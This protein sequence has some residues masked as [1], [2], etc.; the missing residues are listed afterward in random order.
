[1]SAALSPTTPPVRPA[2]TERQPSKC[3]TSAE[4]GAKKIY[5]GHGGINRRHVRFHGESSSGPAAE[6]TKLCP[7]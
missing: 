6:G 1:M 3:E 7:H 2:R 4:F 5:F